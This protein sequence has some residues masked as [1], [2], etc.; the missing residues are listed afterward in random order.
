MRSLTRWIGVAGI[1]RLCLACSSH[2]HSISTKAY[3]RTCAVDSDCVPVYEGTIGCCRGGCANA[4]ING[5]SLTTY[6][7]DLNTRTPV[8]TPAPFC[9]AVT[10]DICHAGAACHNQV[11]EFVS[12]ADA[13]MPTD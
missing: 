11:C 7:D 13:S 5:N 1:L 3:D 6:L 8:C 9:P 2:D 10:D 4:A 12:T